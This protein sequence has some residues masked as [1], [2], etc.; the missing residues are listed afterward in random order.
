[1][2]LS[3]KLAAAAFAALP[4]II[5]GCGGGPGPAPDGGAVFRDPFRNALD[6]SWTWIREA[7][8]AWSIDADGLW[9]A[10]LPGGLMGGGRD[11]ANILVRPLPANARTALVEADANHASQ[12]EQ[13]GLIL[14]HGDDDYAKLVLEYVD[15]EN[16]LVFIAEEDAAPRTVNIVPSTGSPVWLFYQFGDGI[17]K[18][19]AWTRESGETVLGETEFPFEP[20]PKIGVFTQSG[21]PGADRRMR[22]RDFVLDTRDF[23][24][25]SIPSEE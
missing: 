7:P 14:Y 20:A 11:A 3:R 1:M 15:G 23:D 6:G 12:F 2:N 13:G 25:E 16:N 4:A 19:G 18:A 24:P 5:V 9:I 22:F 17:L 10:P 21:E 8:D